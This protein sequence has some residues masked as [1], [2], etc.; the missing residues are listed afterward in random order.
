MISN[1]QLTQRLNNLIDST[2]LIKKISTILDTHCDVF[3]VGGIIRDLALEKEANDIDVC[4]SID[5]NIATRLLKQSLK[6]IETGKKHGTITVLDNNLS[7]EITEFRGEKEDLISDLSLRDFT[8]NAIAFSIKERKIFDPFLGLNDLKNN[9]LRCP[10][11]PDKVFTDDPLRLLRM[12]RFSYAEGRTPENKLIQS[13]IKNFEKIKLVSIE[14]IKDEL[15]NILTSPAPSLALEKLDEFKI[16]NIL[17]PELSKMK[18]CT[19]NK[20]HKA[21]VFF[22]TLD[23]VSK[24]PPILESRLAAFLHDVGKPECIS[25]DENNERHFY[26]HEKISVKIAQTFLE[27]LCFPKKVQ[28]KVLNA[29]S[30]HMRSLESGPSGIRRLIRDL[31]DNFNIWFSL[32][33]ADKPPMMSNDEFEERLKKFLENYQNEIDKKE[34]EDFFK[35]KISGDDIME[36]LNIPPGKELGK[37]KKELE[38]LV[39]EDPKKNTKEWLIEFLK[40][41][42]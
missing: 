25:I 35:L 1:K 33:K 31:G 24:T 15:S 6:V 13:I 17:F 28:Q 18:G 29:I 7:I 2:N 22:H 42:K 20:Y 10:I 12:F 30:L 14:R 41:K 5:I 26:G 21:D 36:L 27:R 19:Q 39:L 23:V 8:I 34:K 9:I 11:N 40:I 38:E 37:I 4:I 16:F 32:I 3:L